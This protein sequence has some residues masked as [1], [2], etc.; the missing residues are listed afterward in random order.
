MYLYTS[1]K[2]LFDLRACFVYDFDID[3]IYYI[4]VDHEKY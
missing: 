4:E 2:L 1:R 3:I